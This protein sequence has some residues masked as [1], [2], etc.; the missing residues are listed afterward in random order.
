MTILNYLTFLKDNNGFATFKELAKDMGI[1]YS[2]MN[3][4]INGMTQNITS[5]YIKYFLNYENK[6]REPD[7]YLTKEDITFKSLADVS[8]QNVVSERVLMHLINKKNCGNSFNENVSITDYRL[9]SNNQYY[10]GGYYFKKGSGANFTLVDDWE[11]LKE[12]HW[13]K[14]FQKVSKR[15]YSKNSY[16]ESAAFSTIEEYYLD[17]LYYAIQK[18]NSFEKPVIYYDIVFSDQ[19]DEYIVKKILHNLKPTF[20]TYFLDLKEELKYENLCHPSFESLQYI[21]LL[22]FDSVSYENDA[23]GFFPI[24]EKKSIL[25][26]VK[27][28]IQNLYYQGDL[29]YC[30]TKLDLSLNDSEGLSLKQSLLKNIDF[31]IIHEENIQENMLMQ[32]YMRVLSAYC[33]KMNLYNYEKIQQLLMPVRLYLDKKKEL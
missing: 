4:Y 12:D 10:F 24:E 8:F 22:Y 19:I 2:V 11:Y 33:S 16:K 14:K 25:K 28:L 32:D 17:V 30:K 5:N 23:R 9:P 31:L 21:D 18:A 26:A 20:N 6:N 1:N 13:C 7:E 27:I 3:G 29:L 15:T